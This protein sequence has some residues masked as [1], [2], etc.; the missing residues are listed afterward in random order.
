MANLD[1]TEA[2]IRRAGCDFAL[3]FDSHRGGYKFA[4]APGVVLTAAEYQILGE[5]FAARPLADLVA[6]QSSQRNRL[7]ARASEADES[8]R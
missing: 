1:A 8:A 7:R 2:A 5:R 6:A 3:C 4:L